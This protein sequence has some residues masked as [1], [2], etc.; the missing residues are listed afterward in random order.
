MPAKPKVRDAGFMRI[1]ANTSGHLWDRVVVV[2]AWPKSNIEKDGLLEDIAQLGNLL[3][4]FF[5]V[6]LVDADSID[7]KPSLCT[8][9]PMRIKNCLIQAVGDGQGPIVDADYCCRHGGAPQR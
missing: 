2:A 1:R 6:V 3:G 8:S 9:F 7:L 5:A 4:L